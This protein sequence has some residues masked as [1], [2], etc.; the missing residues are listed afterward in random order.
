MAI[1]CEYGAFDN[2]H[3][4]LPRTRYDELIDEQS[5]RPGEQTFEKMSAGLYLGEIFRQILLDLMSRGV[6]FRDS[7][8]DSSSNSHSE[9]KPDRDSDS[10]TKKKQNQTLTQQQKDV[11]STPYVIDTEFLSTVE[12]DATPSLAEAKSAFQHV[13]AGLTPSR[14]ELQFC[15]AVAKLIAI[16]GARLCAC[17]ASAISRRIGRRRGHVAADGSVAVKHPRFKERWECAVREILDMKMGGFG[18][19]G[20]GIELT[21]AEDGSGVGAAVICALTMGRT[22]KSLH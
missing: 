17:G 4:V 16:R 22:G 6:I 15:Q 8:M 12:N 20:E 9:P 2:S 19:E 14:A 3:A 18:R 1:N 11:L 21:S 10:E 5:P 13:L 7:D